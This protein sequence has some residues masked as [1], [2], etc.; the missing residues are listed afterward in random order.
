MTVKVKPPDAPRD[1]KQ[2][3]EWKYQLKLLLFSLNIIKEL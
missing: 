2:K 1:Q 3:S